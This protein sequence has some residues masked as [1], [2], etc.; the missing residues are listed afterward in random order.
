M[1]AQVS[2]IPSDLCPDDVDRFD[3]TRKPEWRYRRA[4]EII[5]EYPRSFRSDLIADP[6]IR[7]VH[8]FLRR[9]RTLDAA[10]R[11][12]LQVTFRGLYEAFEISESADRTPRFNVECRILAGQSDREISE[13]LQLSADTVKW[14]QLVHFNVRDRLHATDWI[15]RMVL[16]PARAG[17]L[18]EYEYTLKKHAYFGGPHVFEHLLTASQDVNRPRNLKDLR[19]RL[20][21]LTKVQIEFATLVELDRDTCDTETASWLK[22]AHHQKK[23]GKNAWKI[24]PEERERLT[25]GVRAFLEVMKPIM[26]EKWAATD[27]PFD[28]D[29]IMPPL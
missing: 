24:S 20:E 10:A 13:T 25:E 17:K 29:D 2:L 21:E 28:D 5:D 3:P 14:Y 26:G 27:D 7:V 12:Q 22:G 9:R 4:L 18:S 16:M 6:A 1:S 15:M 23:Y 19:E 8:A 11:S